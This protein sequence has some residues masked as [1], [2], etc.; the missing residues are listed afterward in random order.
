MCMIF[1]ISINDFPVYDKSL[2]LHNLQLIVKKT[3]F[4]LYNFSSGI[5]F[6]SNWNSTSIN[7]FFKGKR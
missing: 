5:D 2:S 7:N 6:K 3:L 4:K 1:K